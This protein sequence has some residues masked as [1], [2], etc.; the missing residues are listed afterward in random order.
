MHERDLLEKRKISVAEAA[1]YLGVTQL[2][3]RILIREGRLPGECLGANKRKRYYIQPAG[4]ISYRLGKEVA[5]EIIK[6]F[7][8][9]N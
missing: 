5:G 6:D 4:L 1:E 7:V 3:V 9:Q 2:T 8:L